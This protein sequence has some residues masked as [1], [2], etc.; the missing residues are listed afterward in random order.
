MLNSSISLHPPYSPP[1][2][3]RR[4]TPRPAWTPSAAS[5]DAPWIDAVQPFVPPSLRDATWRRAPMVDAVVAVPISPESA[6][7]AMQGA[8]AEVSAGVAPES[9]PEAMQG[10]A[11]EVSAGV[12]PKDAPE[13]THEAPL[14]PGLHPTPLAPR[15]VQPLEALPISSSM[16]GE[17][18][19]PAAAPEDELPSISDYLMDGTVVETD[20]TALRWPIADVGEAVSRLTAAL[21]L[22]GASES[23]DD[24]TH[25]E[26]AATTRPEGATEAVAPWSDDEAW[27]D[28]MPAALPSVTRELEA[29]TAWARAFAE[30]P[31]PV[32]AA[33]ATSGDVLTA[34]RALEDVARRLRA[35]DLLLPIWSLE[36]GEPA[37]LA[38][39]LTALLGA[40]R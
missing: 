21:P 22:G 8:A 39:T 35:G 34:A 11:A 25:D 40:R 13:D 27:L 2:T 10:A 24:R 29:Q 15:A 32:P 26:V 6:P 9:A 30:P 33:A 16:E 14:A 1:P 3:D 37:A 19:Y 18:S 36:G 38:A 5:A 28:I 7:E 31:A 4:S 17:S 23:R 12:A 20:A